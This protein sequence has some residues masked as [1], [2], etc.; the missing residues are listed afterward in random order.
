MT[1]L[2]D[3]DP[4]SGI[5]LDG[6]SNKTKK[7]D[8][9]DCPECGSNYHEPISQPDYRWSKCGTGHTVKCL[10]C[11]YIYEVADDCTG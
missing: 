10:S 4:H 1:F 5:G 9:F 8:R 6:T 2:D 11:G 7:K 3:Y